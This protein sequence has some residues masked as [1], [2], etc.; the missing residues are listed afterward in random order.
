M[1]QYA[2][3]SRYKQG[4]GV[5]LVFVVFV[6]FLVAAISVSL[7]T[8]QFKQIRQLENSRASSQILQYAYGVEA[9][10]IEVLKRD[11]AESKLDHLDEA[12]TQPL[13]PTEI[14]SR[15]NKLSGQITD[16]TSLFDINRLA[17]EGKSNK[18]SIQQFKTLL[19]QLDIDT[20]IADKLA[21]WIDEDQSP[22]P[23]G[24]ESTYY[25]TLEPAYRTPDQP[26]RNIDELMF[27]DGIDAQALQKLHTSVTSLPE[28]T[29]VNV[30]TMPAELM[31]THIPGLDLSIAET[32]VEQRES[33]P[34]KSPD[35]F[36]NQLI[37]NSSTN[38]ENAG[39][40]INMQD[41]TV[42][43]KYFRVTSTVEYDGSIL[44]MH[45]DIYRD[46]SGSMQVYQ[47]DMR[48]LQ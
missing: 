38:K 31:V 6:V 28:I 46:P 43:S 29:Q 22:Q 3:I 5:A 40:K 24:A 34:W 18:Q 19:N 21:D 9:W 17:I 15:G 44:T 13:V 45:S 39:Y 10:A 36:V 16:I 33:E 47:R 48:F 30:N 14:D 4:I 26:I 32:M 37:D 27:I 35:E 25:T 1:R 2:Y 20:G 12:W 42:I 23:E 7:L 8:D 41:L 11:Q